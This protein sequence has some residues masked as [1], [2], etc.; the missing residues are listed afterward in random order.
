MDTQ[1]QQEPFGTLRTQMMDMQQAG[2]ASSDWSQ[3]S[4]G[5]FKSVLFYCLMILGAPVLS[6]FVTRFYVLGGV[7]GWD[8]SAVSTEVTSAVVAVVVLHIAL[9][10]FIVRAYF[11]GDEKT[12][13]GKSD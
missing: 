3:N 5:D 7:L 9:G 4:Y 11:S 6:F 2:S 12:K 10:F 8:P 1:Q 13:I